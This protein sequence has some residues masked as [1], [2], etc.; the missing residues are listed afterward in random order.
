MSHKRIYLVTL[1]LALVLPILAACG[2]GTGETTPSGAA[3]PS[4]AASAAASPA[5]SAAPEASASASP[6]ASSEA[7]PS[8]SASTAAEASPA[9]TAEAATSGTAGGAATLDFSKL[10]VED[11]ATLRFLAAGNTTEQ[12]LYTDAAKRF[13][14]TFPNATLNFEPVPAEYETTITAGFSGG[15]APD[16]FLLNGQLMGQLAPQGLLLPLD[17]AMSQVGRQASDYYEQLIQLYQQDGK[18]YGLPK[19]F[20]PLVLF[21]NTDLA[22]QA[23]V[24]PTTIQSWDDLRAAAEKMTQGEG[25]SKVFGLCLTPDI[26]R[27]GASM[28]Q[29]N[30]PIIENNTA[31][32]NNEQGVQAIQFW[33]DIQQAGF[34]ATFQDLSAG[35]CGEAFAK[36]SA[37]MAVEGGW[38]VPFMAD[39]QQGGQ[40]VKYTAV[41]L[42]I[43]EGGQQ[44]SLLFTNGF[45]ANAQSQ[46]PKAAAAA[47]LFLTSEQNQQALIPTGLAQPS[48]QSLASDPYFQDNEVAKVLV[49][50]GQNGRVSDTLFGGPAKKADV[51][52][53][54]NQS[55]IEQILVGGSDVKG[56]LDQAAQEVDQ[57]LQR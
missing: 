29:N 41:P 6:E 21:V 30:N 50:A 47:V 5:A 26:E 15:N 45:A 54:I 32:F 31:V 4:A 44:T 53:A 13:N 1:L 18:T 36:Q 48:L 43:P 8:A 12:Q 35:W 2:G 56:A 16:V 10:E 34:A 52:R 19:D 40:D 39:P 17:D 38:I 28:L 51:V 42:P 46:Y 55:G 27:Y 14:E 33:K 9:G 11:G 23:G 3:S 25:A 37:A 49:Q 57:I 20:N 24:D 7:S 22:Q